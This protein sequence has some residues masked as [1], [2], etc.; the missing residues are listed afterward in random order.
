MLN[1]SNKFSLSCGHTFCRNDWREYLVKKVEEG[2]SGIDARCMQAGCNMRVGHTVFEQLLPSSK[3][4]TYWKW[5]CKSYTDDNKR[6]K[7]CPALGCEM[8]YEKSIYSS[9]TEVRCDCGGSFCFQCGK[10]SHK[11]ADCDQAQLWDEKNTAESS[12]LQWIMANTKACPNCKKP[13]EKNQGCNHMKCT[14]CKFEFCWIC[15][16]DWT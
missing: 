8:C 10:E 13:I 7:W 12:N 5:L 2:S 16:G 3:L 1:N 4:E 6:I 14:T 9:I 11:P 15:L